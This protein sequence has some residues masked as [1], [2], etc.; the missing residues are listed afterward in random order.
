[1][2]CFAR[3]GQVK[4]CEGLS[5]D[6]EKDREVFA[7]GEKRDTYTP[8]RFIQITADGTAPD[9]LAIC[10]GLINK[11]ELTEY[12]EKAV[13]ACPKIL[14]LEDLVAI[15]GAEW[16]FD[17]PTIEMAA[18]RSEHF[19]SVAGFKRYGRTGASRSVP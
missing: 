17:A 14:L 1:M 4:C 7:A 13:K 10:R 6:T 16:G 15:Y 3:W 12:L 19:D 2:S 9:W 11:G 5:A 8:A 18:A